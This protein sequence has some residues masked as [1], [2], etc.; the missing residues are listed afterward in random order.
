MNN[1]FSAYIVR[2]SFMHR[3]NPS[4]KLII[5]VMFIVM[6]F[7]PLG[8]FGQVILLTILIVG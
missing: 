7:L 8:F 5:L 2:D 4:L 6:I 3:F 1:G